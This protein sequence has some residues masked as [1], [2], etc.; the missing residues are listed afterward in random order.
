SVWEIPRTS[1]HQLMEL[2]RFLGVKVEVD[3]AVER[4]VK[5]V[6]CAAKGEEIPFTVRR[7]V[8]DA[9][10]SVHCSD[11]RLMDA[12][13]RMVPV[14]QGQTHLSPDGSGLL[15]ALHIPAVCSFVQRLATLPGVVKLEGADKIN[16]M[17]H[18]SDAALLSSFN[19]TAPTAA[20]SAVTRSSRYHH[21]HRQSRRAFPRS[22]TRTSMIA[23]TP[24]RAS[25]M[26][27]ESIWTLAR[28]RN[29]GK[30]GRDTLKRLRGLGQVVAPLPFSP[31]PAGDQHLFKS[32]TG[33]SASARA[34]A[35]AGADAG[36]A[37]VGG[38]PQ[39]R[40]RR[41]AASLPQF[42]GQPDFQGLPATSAGAQRQGWVAGVVDTVCSSGG[43]GGLM[44]A[45]GSVSLESLLHQGT[46]PPSTSHAPREEP[47]LKK[48][49]TDSFSLSDQAIDNVNFGARPVLRTSISD[50][51]LSWEHSSDEETPSDD[52]TFFPIA[53]MAQVGSL[54]SPDDGLNGMP[55]QAPLPD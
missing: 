7:W 9:V 28:D 37:A 21:D 25:N 55:A 39:H 54:G 17:F 10:A 13:S 22:S 46:I 15:I 47:G 31:T 11:R 6:S 52:R 35:R 20:S 2:H 53:R 5:E 3:V 29:W 32:G 42:S 26:V 36:A 40:A 43:D 8:L 45:A 1:T 16:V 33:A 50:E 49:R 24:V 4:L 19:P 34:G 12:M 30:P 51:L 41:G 44:G 38:F 18:R 23:P 27:P 48:R 14:T